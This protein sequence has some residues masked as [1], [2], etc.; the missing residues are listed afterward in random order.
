M[1]HDLI[2]PNSKKKDILRSNGT[3]QM[4]VI[5]WRKYSAAI[6]EFEHNLHTQEY[7]LNAGAFPK[8][9]ELTNKK[10]VQWQ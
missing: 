6:L 5:C 3:T 8:T 4:L 2:G 7:T 10:L 1:R 9:L